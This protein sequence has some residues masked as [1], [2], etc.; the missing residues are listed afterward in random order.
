VPIADFPDWFIPFEGRFVG[1]FS[2]R[3][4]LFFG[5]VRFL[6]APKHHWR[7]F[8]SNHCAILYILYIS[9]TWGFRKTGIV[10]FMEHLRIDNS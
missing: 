10:L 4:L 5:L 2:C 9:I 6:P 8:Y 3:G 7:L 1:G